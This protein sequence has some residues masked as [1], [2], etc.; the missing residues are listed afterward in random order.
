[1]LLRWEQRDLAERSGVSLPTI[2]RLETKPGEMQAHA[3]TVEALQSALVFAG[4]VFIPAGQYQGEDGPG[5]RLKTSDAKEPG[6]IAYY[7]DLAEKAK[8]T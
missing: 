8:G 5:V 6:M 4:I 7:R 2:K 3:S 1:M